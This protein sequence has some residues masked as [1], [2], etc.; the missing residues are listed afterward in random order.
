MSLPHPKIKFFLSDEAK[1]AE[2]VFSPPR[3]LDAGFDLPSLV[4]FE[5]K[6][7]SMLLVRTGLHVAIPENWV[8]LVRDRSSIALR[9]CITM[10]G[11]VDASYRGEI[12]VVMYNLASAAL[13]FESGERI[14]QMVIVP[15]LSGEYSGEV[16]AIDHLGDTSRGSG[17]FGSTGKK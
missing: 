1:K 16:L 3:A 6:P 14:A 12:K 15:H 11:V 2:V 10:A 17:G 9:G 13:K 5:I 4:D 7:Q 8:G